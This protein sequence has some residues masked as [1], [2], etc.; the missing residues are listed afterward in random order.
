MASTGTLAPPP[1]PI[2]NAN[3]TKELLLLHILATTSITTYDPNNPVFTQGQDI[4]DKIAADFQ[5]IARPGSKW[6]WDESKY[7]K[8]VT[9]TDPSLLMANA[10][11]ARATDADAISN[12][13]F[14]PAAAFNPGWTGGSTHPD[15]TETANL[16]G[17]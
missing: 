7:T 15:I 12:L 2:N 8:T 17:M 4:L 9:G 3:L 13:S 10:L 14:Q 1:R 6:N 5:T 16:L 11:V